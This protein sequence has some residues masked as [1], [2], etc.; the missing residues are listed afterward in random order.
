MPKHLKFS[1][2]RQ[3]EKAA[4]VKQRTVQTAV[5]VRELRGE[6]NADAHKV[7]NA[8]SPQIF[9]LASPVSVN[10]TAALAARSLIGSIGALRKNWH[11]SSWRFWASCPKPYPSTLPPLRLS[12]AL[13]KR[14]SLWPTR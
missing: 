13:H 14:R 5:R 11:L 4:K 6:I 2:R 7:S 10:P 1:Q 8:A 9:A 12:A 3:M